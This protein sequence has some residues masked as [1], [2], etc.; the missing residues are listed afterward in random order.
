MYKEIRTTYSKKDCE[1]SKCKKPINKGSE[2]IIN[3]KTKEAWHTKCGKTK[4][5]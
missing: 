1:C 3:P 2:I 5:E 4:A